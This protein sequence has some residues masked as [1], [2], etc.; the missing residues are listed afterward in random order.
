MALEKIGILIR[1]I[2]DLE[3]VNG[4]KNQYINNY[5]YLQKRIK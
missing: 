3:K 5:Y 1:S 2:D 4:P